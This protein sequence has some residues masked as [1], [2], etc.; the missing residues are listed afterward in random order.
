MCAGCPHSAGHGD[1][2]LTLKGIPEEQQNVSL[3]SAIVSE[4]IAQNTLTGNSS[5]SVKMS[6]F[7][8][9]NPLVIDPSI[10]DFVDLI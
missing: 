8:L 10:D 5:Y 4:V 1:H 9:V 3:L 2:T 7:T 6:T